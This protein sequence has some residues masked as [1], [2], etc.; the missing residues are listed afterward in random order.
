M[1]QRVSRLETLASL[2][3]RGLMFVRKDGGRCLWC[4]AVADVYDSE[5]S[6]PFERDGVR[7]AFFWA[8]GY[9]A[10]CA[11][12]AEEFADRCSGDPR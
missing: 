12:C 7:Y 6:L 4:S 5:Y 9:V 11:G 8:P 1:T 3:R 10:F 2:R